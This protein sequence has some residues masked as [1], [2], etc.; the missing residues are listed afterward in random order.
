MPAASICRLRKGMVIFM[1]QKNNVICS[2]LS[3]PVVFADFIN[4]S[5]HNGEK[6]VFPDQLM[7][8]ER[9]THLKE[10]PP[11]VKRPSGKPKY[12]ERQ[13]D[14][15]KAVFGGDYYIVIGIEAQNKVDY[16]M[17]IRCME[18]DVT[19]YKRQL[20]ERSRSREGKLSGGEFLSGMAKEEKMNPVITIVFYHGEEPY[21][22]CMDLHDMLELK[23]ENK[24]CQRIVYKRF[25]ADYHVNLVKAGDLDEG[26]FETGL[27]CIKSLRCKIPVLFFFRV[28]GK[29]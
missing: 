27:L 8:R 19:E 3:N 2:Y 7:D 25:I 29:D 1:G 6:V 17:P 16:A 23:E 9:V 20:R 15:L 26:N 12:V 21:A 18:Y 5:I 22:G 13:R 4:G 11:P 28:P 10:N 24:T 14:S